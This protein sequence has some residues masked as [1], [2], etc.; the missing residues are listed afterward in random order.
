MKKNRTVSNYRPIVK[1]FTKNQRE[2]LQVGLPLVIV[3]LLF[4]P[5]CVTDSTNH[6][7][8]NSNIEIDERYEPSSNLIGINL[9]YYVNSIAVGNTTHGRGVA[10][11]FNDTLRFKDPVNLV[12]ASVNIGFG[13][14]LYQTLIGADV[15]LDGHTEFLFVMFNLTNTNLVVVDFDGGGSA[16]EYNYDAI[17]DP[18]GI[19]VGDFNGDS[20]IDVGVYSRIRLVMKDLGSDSLIGVFPQIPFTTEEIVKACIGNFSLV[21]GDEIAVM[22]VQDPWTSSS[23]MLVD[24]IFG[25][26]TSIN[27]TPLQS[28]SHVHG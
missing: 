24:T 2:L 23:R 9:P 11:I 10:W 15:D 7:N 26:G 12:D 5:M 13:D 25:D 16:T 21:P 4:M 20:L 6:P 14:P 3:I 18:M 19:I 22:Y 8:A 17:P 1:P 28:S 27:P